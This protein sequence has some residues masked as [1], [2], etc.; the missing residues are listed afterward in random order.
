MHLEV[1]TR[2]GEPC[3]TERADRP[4]LPDAASV[5][6]GVTVFEQRQHDGAA[7]SSRRPELGGPCSQWTGPNDAP[8]ECSVEHRRELLP[9]EHAP[10]IDERSG[11]RGRRNAV[12]RRDI[13]RWKHV[14]RASAAGAAAARRPMHHD[15]DRAFVDQAV[16][17]SRTHAAR[18]AAGCKC[19][20][21]HLLPPRAR[22]GGKRPKDARVKLLPPT[23]LDAPTHGASCEARTKRLFARED[24]VLATGIDGQASVCDRR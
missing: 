13:G 7:R 6:V 19:V 24:P 10:E 5:D 17:R 20:R 12:H 9:R 18:E 3:C 8:H 4:L 16:E 22:R 2:R 11:G 15:I 21:E 23:A 14:R 1:A